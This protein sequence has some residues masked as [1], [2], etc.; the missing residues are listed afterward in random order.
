MPKAK[1]L[2]WFED[3]GKCPYCHKR[4]KFRV[5]R[6]VLKAAQKA[7]IQITSFVE[8]DDQTELKP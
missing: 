6:E 8:K 7:E 2:Y 1:K 3:V 5:K 4:F